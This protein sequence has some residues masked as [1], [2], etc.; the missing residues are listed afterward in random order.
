MKLKQKKRHLYIYNQ[1]KA[2]THKIELF[3]FF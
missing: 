1:M 3:V 2:L